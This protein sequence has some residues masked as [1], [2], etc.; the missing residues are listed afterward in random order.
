MSL[1]TP[2]TSVALQD[3][4]DL[5]IDARAV[6]N[7]VDRAAPGLD[8]AV[9]GPDAGPTI[10]VLGTFS[11]RAGDRNLALTGGT[12][13][14]LALL[15]L[16][17]Q[18]M[19]RQLVA[20]TLW[21]D[22]SEAE[23]SSRLRSAL[24]RLRNRVGDVVDVANLD[25]QLR[26]EVGVDLHDARSLVHGLFERP[27]R[28]LWGRTPAAS[29]DMLSGDLLPG[30]DDPWVL[31]ESGEWHQVRLHALEAMAEHLVAHGRC[32]DA[33]LA[34]L[35]VLRAEPMRE[36]AHGALIKTFLAEGNQNEALEQFDRFRTRLGVELGVEPSSRLSGLVGN[37]HRRRTDV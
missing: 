12:R 16:R 33:T 37:L 3:F 21:P 20:Y 13:R 22:A 18:P 8:L 27:G 19:T 25:L 7:D 5:S 10:S 29:V 15:A 31:A 11:F 30:W 14:L 2:V 1:E 35:A 36:S 6:D 17:R 26:P 4:V 23:A 34:A 28:A 32:A 9:V 24:C